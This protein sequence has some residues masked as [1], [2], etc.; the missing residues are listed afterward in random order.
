MQ[1]CFLIAFTERKKGTLTKIA[2]IWC[3]VFTLKHYT[4]AT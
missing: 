4:G 1:R 3:S 2:P